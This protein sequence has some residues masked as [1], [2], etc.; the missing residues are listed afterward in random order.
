MKIRPIFAVYLLFALLITSCASLPERSDRLSPADGTGVKNILVINTNQ[1]LER[2]KV[3]Q[4]SFIET[5]KLTAADNT[6]AISTIDLS[7]DNTPIE[8]LQDVLNQRHFD[9]IYCI[10]AK[11]LGSIDYID[12]DTQVVFSSVLSWRHFIEQP[13]YFGVASETAHEAQLTWFKYFFPELRTIGV[14]YSSDNR[15]LVKK[16]RQAA[17]K[18]S[19]NIIAEEVASKAKLK[20]Q[21]EDLLPKVDALWLISDATVLGSTQQAKQLFTLAHQHQTPV[22][23]YNPVFV[24]MGAIFSIAA[25]TPTTGRQAALIMNN[26]LSGSSPESSIQYPAGSHISVNLRKVREYNIELNYNALDSVNSL[27]GE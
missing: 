15:A 12:P 19:I 16:A 24:E 20:A 11:A 3:S 7:M 22:L 18:L 6:R 21:T 9:A 14:L 1:T 13:N 5:L 10:G 4:E 8:T 27:I 2:Y 23:A 26:L 17:S 25:D